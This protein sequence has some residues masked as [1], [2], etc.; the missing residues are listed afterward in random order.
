M[1]YYNDLSFFKVK[2]GYFLQ[3][4]HICSTK[5]QLTMAASAKT[6][7]ASLVTATQKLFLA[8]AGEQVLSF[9]K[10]MRKTCEHDKDTLQNQ[11]DGKL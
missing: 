8:T 7:K 4:H 10:K 5:T 1:Q 3:G 2:S 9:C 11:T 6:Q